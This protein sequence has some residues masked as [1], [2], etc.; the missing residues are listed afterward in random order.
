MRIQA[1]KPLFAWDAL[2]DSPTLKTIKQL[3]DVIPDEPLLEGLQQ[4]RGKGR[5]D[6]PLR[7]AW[8]CSC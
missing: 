1:T 3:L 8:G 7:V 6:V 5:N 4:A 2:E